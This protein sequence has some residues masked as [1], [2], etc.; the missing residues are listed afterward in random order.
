MIVYKF[1]N[2]QPSRYRAAQYIPHVVPQSQPRPNPYRQSYPPRRFQRYQSHN[3][4][5]YRE[6]P[7]PQPRP[8]YMPNQTE[9]MSTLHCPACGDVSCNDRRFCRSRSKGCN[10]CQRVG[11]FSAMCPSAKPSK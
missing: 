3:N 9:N 1:H 4:S 11:H 2:S 10:T 6:P 7:E 8:R 5:N